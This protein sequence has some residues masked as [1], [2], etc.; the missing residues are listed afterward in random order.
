MTTPPPFGGSPDKIRA[1]AGRV[2]GAADGVKDCVSAAAAVHLSPNAF[3][4]LV[5]G[6]IYPRADS[7]QQQG[8]AAVKT[9]SDGLDKIVLGIGAWAQHLEGVEQGLTLGFTRFADLLG[10]G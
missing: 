8:A 7:A 10:G 2:Q 3:G 6:L 4:E 9:T 5:G 1:H